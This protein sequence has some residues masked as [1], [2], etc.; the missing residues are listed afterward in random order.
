MAIP[1]GTA[2]GEL[3][4]LWWLSPARRVRLLRPI[5]AAGFVPFLLFT[6]APALLPSLAVGARRLHDTDR[7]GWWLLIGLVPVVGAI[8]LLVWFC[9]RPDPRPNRFG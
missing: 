9:Q 4:A 2:I 5:A 6:F 7:S 3:G 1:A 8:L